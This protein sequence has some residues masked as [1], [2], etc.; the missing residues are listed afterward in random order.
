MPTLK[1][2]SS[3]RDRSSGTEPPDGTEVEHR[4][5]AL[6]TRL[7]TILPTLATKGDLE[8]VRADIS[9]WMIVTILAIIG[10]MLAA[11]F[12]VAQVFKGQQPI[13]AAAQQPP[14][15]INNIPPQQTAPAVDKRR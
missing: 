3:P 9:R 11:I 8:A 15:I 6:E 1:L 12:G 13:S 2:V 4:L 5:T 7:D 14:I 10:T